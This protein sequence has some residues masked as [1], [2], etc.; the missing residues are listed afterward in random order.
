MGQ[1]INHATNTTNNQFYKILGDKLAV[2][3]LLSSVFIHSLFFS[4]NQFLPAYLSNLD[5]G[6]QLLSFSRTVN[7]IVVLVAGLALLGVIKKI[8]H[9]T[10]ILWTTFFYGLLFVLLFLVINNEYL[11]YMVSALVSVFYFVSAIG[12]KT[13]Y[14][15]R[16]DNKN[17]GIYLSAFSLTGRVGNI[18]AALIL[19]MSG[20]VGYGGT[21]GILALLAI[22]AIGWLLLAKTA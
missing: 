16:I 17:S 10:P 22:L 15:N 6:S 18:I 7:G 4:L 1:S 9:Y 20:F 2:Y 21:V 19:M 8:A 11:F 13:I 3:L 12:I 14:A 5:N